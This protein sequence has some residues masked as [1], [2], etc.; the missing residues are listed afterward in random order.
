MVTLKMLLEQPGWYSE[1]PVYVPTKASDILDRIDELDFPETFPDQQ[2][3]DIWSVKECTLELKSAKE[4]EAIKFC[5]IT[6]RKKGALSLSKEMRKMLKF[7]DAYEVEKEEE[8]K[9]KS[10]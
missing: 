1:A 4:K 9:E 6:F 3:A 8:V 10:E 5:L 7:F 2:T